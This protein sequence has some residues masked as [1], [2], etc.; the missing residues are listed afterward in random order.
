MNI[1]EKRTEIA[2]L[3]RQIN[4]LRHQKQELEQS[5]ARSDAAE[6]IRMTGMTKDQV[7]LSTGPGVP[8]FGHVSGFATWLKVQRPRKRWCEWNT[9]IYPTAEVIDGNFFPTPVTLSDLK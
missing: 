2:N 3:D 1:T 4:N 7:Q 6:F 5:I 8:W 9:C